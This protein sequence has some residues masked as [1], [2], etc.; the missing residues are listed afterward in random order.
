MRAGVGVAVG[1]N[2]GTRIRLPVAVAVGVTGVAVAVGASGATGVVIGVATVI[3]VVVVMARG[4]ASE[5][6]SASVATGRLAGTF[7]TRKLAIHAPFA[8][9]YQFPLT[10][11]AT[12]L[13]RCPAPI[14]P[15]RAKEISGPAR[16]LAVTGTVLSSPAIGGVGVWVTV[17]GGV[18]VTGVV[19]VIGVV[20]VAG[21]VTVAGTV[22]V[23]VAV[24]VTG[25]V[26]AS[27]AV[28][29]AVALIVGVVVAV[30]V[31]VAADEITR[32]V[33]AGPMGL[34]GVT[35]T[36]VVGGA[37]KVRETGRVTVV[38]LLNVNVTDEA[39]VVV[40]VRVSVKPRSK[41]KVT[42]TVCVGAVVSLVASVA[43]MPARGT[44]NVMG[45]CWR[46]TTRNGWGRAVGWF[47][48][49]PLWAGGPATIGAWRAITTN[50]KL[51][52]IIRQLVILRVIQY[53][54]ES[55]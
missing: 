48:R 9:K 43:A 21:V 27:V 49:C 39:R 32:V 6:I 31:A 50:V 11:C 33:K 52:A 37:L 18:A 1:T 14:C 42:A 19:V 8:N 13:T 26:T 53:S 29:V 34:S 22:A 2:V 20:A 54:F 41:L 4:V 36:S 45:N 44:V 55:R 5:A 24:A 10:S 40:S 3:A 46:T 38:W 16:K 7:S 51:S 28:A 30:A 12:I 35:L 23:T 15:A 47:A 17:M 25:V